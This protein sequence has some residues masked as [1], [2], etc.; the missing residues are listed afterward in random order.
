[1]SEESFISRIEQIFDFGFCFLLFCILFSRQSCPY[2]VIFWRF[3]IFSVLFFVFAQHFSESLEIS[4]TSRG[5][6]RF[7]I[8]NLNRSLVHFE[9]FFNAVF[10]AGF[11]NLI[12]I[13]IKR[14]TFGL[15]AL[16][17]DLFGSGFESFP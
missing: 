7:F 15:Y 14:G 8:I 3:S 16:Y 5:R 1:M 2:F 17:F 9:A 4:R 11:R 6:F 13:K 12:N 10:C